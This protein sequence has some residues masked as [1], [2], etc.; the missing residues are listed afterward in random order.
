V[1][2]EWK[3]YGVKEMK[4][5][6]KHFSQKLTKEEGK[7]LLEEWEVVKREEWTHLCAACNKN[8]ADVLR[9][10]MNLECFEKYPAIRKLALFALLIPASTVWVERG[11][12][13]MKLV[14]SERRSTMGEYMLSALMVVRINEERKAK[15]EMSAA[16][17]AKA[18]RAWKAAKRRTGVHLNKIRDELI[19]AEREVK[20][21]EREEKRR[22]RKEEA[23]NEEDEIPEDVPDSDCVLEEDEKEEEGEE[24]EDSESDSGDEVEENGRDEVDDREVKEDED[25]DILKVQKRKRGM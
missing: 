17:K 16:L 19:F 25:V 1:T 12:S 2:P 4:I 15:G 21:K 9:K 11:F 13:I 8:T 22:S 23:E 7:S 18:I 6:G 24:R 3:N 5:L 14:K 10:I 20:K